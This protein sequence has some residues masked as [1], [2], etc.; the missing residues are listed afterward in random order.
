MR[1]YYHRS[2]FNTSNFFD[3]FIFETIDDPTHGTVDYLSY[4]AA[5]AQGL[6]KNIKGKV[7]LGVDNTTI[8]TST[9]RGR[10]SLRLLS[11]MKMNGN[12]LIVLDLDHMPSTTGNVLGK[13]CSVWPAFWTL[14]PDWP[15]TGEVDIIE[16][17][18]TDSRGNTALHTSANCDMTYVPLKSFNSTWSI[19]SNGHIPATNCYGYAPNQD[20]NSGCSVGG[21]P[22]SVGYAFN[23]ATYSNSNPSVS[24]RGGVYAMQWDKDSQI[25]TYY[26][27]RNKIPQ[28]LLNK[29]PNPDSWGLPY[30][31]YLIGPRSDCSSSHFRDH[32]MV[33]DTTFCG[34]WAGTDIVL[35]SIRAVLME[36]HIT[37]HWKYRLCSHPITAAISFLI[38]RELF[39]CILLVFILQV[40]QYQNYS[41]TQR[42]SPSP[43]PRRCI[44][45]HLQQDHQLLLL[46]AQQPLRVL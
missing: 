25:R 13:G 34:D 36:Q 24:S 4:S 5:V 18:N 30:S 23:K 8:V 27:P 1:K 16:Y 35:H 29:A 22:N 15:N 6:A 45:L 38:S 39:A 11:K 17:I 10:K 7:Y 31:R 19:S 42:P 37:L 28:D 12:N 9:A 33:F 2:S 3:A 41:H 14:G 21:P 32:Q 20:Q 46:R 43:S 44:P 40:L 26:F